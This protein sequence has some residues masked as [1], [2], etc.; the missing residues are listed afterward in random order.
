MRECAASRSWLESGAWAYSSLCGGCGNR[1]DSE[2]ATSHS[3]VTRTRLDIHSH[4]QYLVRVPAWSAGAPRAATLL[5]L[6]FACL[7]I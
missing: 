3:S 7:A 4:G 5:I 2:P 1:W 6:E